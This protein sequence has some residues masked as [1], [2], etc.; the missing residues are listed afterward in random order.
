MPLYS[1]S[2][3]QTIRLAKP[4]TPAYLFGH[5]SDVG[6]P[7]RFLINQVSGQGHTATVKGIITEGNLPKVGDLITIEGSRLSHFNV[8]AAPVTAVNINPK[9]GIGSISFH[10][11]PVETPYNECWPITHAH[12]YAGFLEQRVELTV[13]MLAGIEVPQVGERFELSGFTHIQLK[14]LNG[15]QRTLHT[16]IFPG[17]NEYAVYHP[18]THLVEFYHPELFGL[19]G[20]FSTNAS[21][22]ITREHE[23]VRPTPSAALAIIPRS[24]ILEEIH[25]G[26]KSIAVAIDDCPE[27]KSV[28]NFS[29][30]LSFADEVPEHFEVEVE[31]SSVNRDR[32]YRRIGEISHERPRF[33]SEVRATVNFVRLHVPNGDRDRAWTERKLAARLLLR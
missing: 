13:G 7:T 14:E 32:D 1:A 15:I 29:I 10:Y 28:Q 33:E 22:T 25:A 2:P 9:T 19:G 6:A 21:L 26:D 20:S 5:F 18:T 3:S 24:P 31:G 4:G 23:D 27:G 17:N 12:L 16:S 8:V 30:D 11:I